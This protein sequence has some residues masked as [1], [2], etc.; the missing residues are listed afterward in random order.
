MK[1]LILVFLS[2]LFFCSVS[3]AG[4]ER[5]IGFHSDILINPDAS[6]IVSETIKVESTGNQIKRG[7]YRDFP[8][9]YK[10]NYGTNY[11]VGFEIVEILRDGNVDS[12][13][14]E[15]L[16]NGTRI[17]IGRKSYYLDPGI[18]TYKITYKTTRQLGYLK[19]YDELYWNVTGNGWDFPIERASA[20]I[21]LPPG[22]KVLDASAYTGYQGKKGQDYT[23]SFAD[24]KAYFETSRVLN[25]EEGL[26]IA[27]A[28]PK[29]LVPEP[30]QKEKIGFFIK[31]NLN[32]IIGIA[33]LL[34]VFLYYLIVWNKVG[35]DPKKGT[36]V[37]FFGPPKDISPAQMRLIM[38]MGF[39]KKC[40]VAAIVNMAIKKNI[41]IEED[42]GDYALKK[43]ENSD[44]NV[45]SS[46]EKVIFKK[47]IQSYG[48]V[49]LDQANHGVIGRAIDK[50][51]GHLSKKSEKIYFLSNTRFFI[52]GILLSIVIILLAL[53]S[54]V[55]DETFIV[56]FLGLW[57]SIWS[58]GVVAIVANALSLWKKFLFS[59]NRAI[60]FFPAL[61]ISLFALPFVIA[62]IVVLGLLIYFGSALL[63]FLIVVLALINVLFFYLLKAPTLLGRQIMDQ[64]EG[65]KLYLSMAEKDRLNFF[66]QPG[67]SPDLFEKFL[68]YAIALDVENKWAEYFSEEFKKA[69]T[70]GQAYSPSWYHGTNFA[71]IG[72][73][74]LASSLGSSFSS[75]VSSASTAPSSSGSSGS[76]GGGSSGGGGGGGGGGGW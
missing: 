25:K 5:I 76:F 43:L 56:G 41:A 61:F 9:K 36:I 29:G 17:Y 18:Y 37:P 42:D 21:S 20:K 30:T 40:F 15:G 60:D 70:E 51:S 31:D 64:I 63:S 57:L 7:I 73:V 39:D 68:P 38:K 66:N 35:R 58:I 11:N 75:A 26:T 65:F 49:E 44:I 14:T 74:G 34:V 6:M 16:S 12:Y 67:K 47:L 33:G 45:L 22:A 13:H 27:V 50:F 1:K 4:S 10:D 28:W 53:F 69:A 46:D 54:N 8:T 3:F 59:Q 55:T 72:A 62:E 19:D 52:P 32:L 71:A 23:V 24:G 48:R 2:V